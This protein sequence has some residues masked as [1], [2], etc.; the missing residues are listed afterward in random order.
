[1]FQNYA[2]LTVTI[3]P[4]QAYFSFFGLHNAL[5]SFFNSNNLYKVNHK[6]G[7]TMNFLRV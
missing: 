7:L 3:Y 5:P 6:N 1:M 2:V 4:E